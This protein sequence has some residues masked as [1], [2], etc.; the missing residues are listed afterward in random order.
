MTEPNLYLKAIQ[1]PLWTDCP[2]V[3]PDGVEVHR[4]AQQVALIA[5][6]GAT[7]GVLLPSFNPQDLPEVLSRIGVVWPT[8]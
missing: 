6:G 5:P 3:L 1:M 8:P 4:S 2:W 7:I